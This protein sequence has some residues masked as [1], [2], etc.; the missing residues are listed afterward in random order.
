MLK[1]S[2]DMPA[3][4]KRIEDAVVAVLEGGWRTGDIFREGPG[5]TKVG[6]KEMG[7]KVR[8][9]ILNSKG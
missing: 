4:A 7:E 2:F 8:Q 3:E 5:V 9:A 1:Y 6:T